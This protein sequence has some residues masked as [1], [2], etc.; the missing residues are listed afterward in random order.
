MFGLVA[1]LCLSLALYLWLQR[2]LPAFWSAVAVITGIVIY[3]DILLLSHSRLAS[4]GYWIACT[5]D[6]NRLDPASLRR[7]DAYFCQSITTASLGVTSGL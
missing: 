1:A 3:L 4:R 6:W 2:I 7:A 5:S